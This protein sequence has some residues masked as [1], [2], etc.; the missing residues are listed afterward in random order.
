MKILF[1]LFLF[2]YISQASANDIDIKC[3]SLTYYNAPVVKAD[4]YICHTLYAV[5]YSYASKNPIYTTEFLSA[6]HIGNFE[7]SNNFRVNPIIPNQYRAYPKDYVK[8]GTVCD[9]DRCDKGHMTPAQDFSSNPITVSESFFMENM[10]PQSAKMNEVS[11]KKL[12]ETIRKYVDSH[13]AGVYVITG[14]I[15]TSST[16]RTLGS[17]KIWVPDEIFK[18]VIDAENGHSIAFV[19]PNSPLPLVDLSKYVTNLTTIENK[20]GIRFDSRLNKLLTAR[21]KDW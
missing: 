9:G 16:P 10:V 8:S 20:T 3:P 13:P 2:G 21:F 11:W 1:Y 14:P 19:M 17:N 7:R 15:Y 5:A 18:V 4:Q 6:S 12:E